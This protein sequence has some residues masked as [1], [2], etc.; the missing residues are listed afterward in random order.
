MTGRLLA[1]ALILQSAEF[2]AIKPYP[3]NVIR[4]EI[5][6]WLRP[7]LQPYRFTVILQLI[8]S[9]FCLVEPA[10]PAVIAILLA[11][12]WL[13]AI[14][15]RG[16]F[17]GASD[18][19]TFLVTVGW[20]ASLFWEKALW[21]IAIQVILSYFVAGVSKLLEGEWRSGRALAVFLGRPRKRGDRLVAWSIIA[22]EVF[23]PA[24]VLSPRVALA[25][26]AGG[27]FFHLINAYVLGLNRFVF[28]WLAA[29][30]ALYWA[31]LRVCGP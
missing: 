13:I 6:Q 16:T 12:Q 22:F 5:P 30:P 28:A 26:M 23:F 4:E 11:T 31:T 18:S 20:L 21:Y 24:A 29:Y 1:L 8:I 10:H 3:W 25:F 19:M 27:L 17:N 2:L 14:R 15:W 7:I 9:L